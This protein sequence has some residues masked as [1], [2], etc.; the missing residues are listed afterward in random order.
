MPTPPAVEQWPVYELPKALAGGRIPGRVAVSFPHLPEPTSDPLVWRWWPMVPGRGSPHYEIRF[1][2]PPAL[3]TVPVAVEGTA[4]LEVDGKRRI[5]K[6]P[7]VI[8]L[9]G[10]CL[11]KSP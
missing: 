6:V 2:T 11:P 8:I 9:E 3:E 10:A 7:G 1:A 4:R 5:G